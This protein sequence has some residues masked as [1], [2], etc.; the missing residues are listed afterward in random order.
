MFKNVATSV[1]LFA[2]DYTTG[3]AKTGDQANISG[4]VAKDYGSATA[5]GTAT[6][7][8]VDATNAPGW[9]KFTVA[10]AETNAN[11][12]LFTAKSSTSNVSVVG[13]YIF[14]TPNLFSSLAIDS[15]GRVTADLPI[16]KRRN[17]AQGGASASITLD[18]SATGAYC[19]AGDWIYIESGSGAGNSN[20]V[21]SYDATSKVA[22][23]IQNWA[24]VPGNPAAGS[25]FQV[26]ANGA[27]LPLVAQVSGTG[28]LRVST[29]EVIGEPISST[30]NV[31]DGSG[32]FTV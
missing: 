22:T 30:G 26:W 8:Q 17:T 2:F 19:Q 16:M 24:T 5:L 20:I 4:Y 7:T 28:K 1:Y 3:A 6:P 27:A 23:M 21:Q 15:I 32:V 9:Y 14:T 10:Q 29:D 11:S 18:A 12:L 25:V 31:S 13:Q